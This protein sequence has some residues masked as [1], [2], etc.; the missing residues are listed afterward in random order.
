MRNKSIIFSGIAIFGLGVTMVLTSKSALKYE[1]YI[2][3]NEPKTKTDKAKLIAKSYWPAFLSA[4]GTVFCII[5][6]QTINAKQLAAISGA[7]AFISNRYSRYREKVIEEIGPE[8]NREIEAK[9]AMDDWGVVS[10][11]LPFDPV[12]DKVLFYDTF[13]GTFFYATVDQVKDAMYHMNRML[14]IRGDVTMAE[15]FEM[16]GIDVSKDENF[17]KGYDINYFMEE[18]GIIPWVD[19]SIGLGMTD[20]GEEYQIIYY[21]WDPCDR[22][23]EYE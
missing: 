6:A 17:K 13:S 3:E 8:K 5:T 4:G 20:D 19:F 18:L 7:V 23:C 21:D 2:K 10:P 1:R 15:F 12:P 9:I 11:Q 16:I 14:Q 22:E